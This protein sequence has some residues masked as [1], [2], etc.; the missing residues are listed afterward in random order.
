MRTRTETK[1]IPPEPEST[2]EETY[3][4]CDKCDFE[5]SEPDEVRKHYGLTHAATRQRKAAD[6]EFAFFETESDFNDFVFAQA[7]ED[8]H[9]MCRHGG[10]WTGPGFYGSEFSESPCGRGC[11]TVWHSTWVSAHKFKKK[12]ESERDKLTEKIEAVW[13]LT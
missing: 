5:A 1:I 4:G 7:E 3:Y 13:F 2:Y 10:V 6:V 12:W 9:G 8:T 11:C